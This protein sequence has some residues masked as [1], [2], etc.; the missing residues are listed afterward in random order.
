M[1]RKSLT[2]QRALPIHHSVRPPGWHP[3]DLPS[4][5]GVTTVYV[6]GETTGV[7]WH[8]GDKPVGWAVK[9]PGEPARYLPF[10]HRGGGNHDEATV[11]RWAECELRGKTI[12]NLHTKFDAHMSRKWGVDWVAQGNTLHDIAHAEAL[13]D[14]W[15]RGFSL[16]AIAQRRLGVGKID[17]G[18]KANIAELPAWDVEAYACRDVDLVEQIDL[19]QR[20]LLIEQDLMRVMAL[21]DEVLAVVVEMEH[22]G[23]P[24]DEERLHLW[25][26]QSEQ[27]LEQ[28]LWNVARLAGFQVT[29]SKNADLKR[30]FQ[31]R[32][33]ANPHRTAGGD[34][35]FTAEFMKTI[36]DPAIA[37]AFRAGKLMD[38]RS[39]F[40]E[41]Y[42]KLLHNG[43]LWPSMHQLMTDEGGTVSGR[44]SMARPNLQ[45]VMTPRKQKR[46]YGTFLIPGG[47]EESFVIKQLFREKDGA[48][49]FCADQEQVE[50]RIFA[51]Y[52]EAKAVLDAYA[53]P[54]SFVDFD[55]KPVAV[56][57]RHADMHAIVTLMI[58]LKRELFP[59]DQA[60]NANFARLY[61]SGIPKFAAM[62]GLELDDAEEV[63][64]IYDSQFPEAK[65]LLKKAMGV[66]NERGYVKTT[67]GR[68]CRFPFKDGTFGPAS[69]KQLRSQRERQR[70]HKALNAVIQGSA[71]D[72]NKRCLVETHKERRRLGMT[73]RLTV[74]DELN[75]RLEDAAMAHAA[76][77]VLNQQYVP[78]K[79]PI[80]WSGATG[81][82]WADAK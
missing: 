33:I 27:A 75:S 43:F 78:L 31:S 67:L 76:L 79:V 7:D 35:S 55:G 58:R 1:A 74:H 50:F 72:L 12:T 2:G 57:G 16:E 24:I 18:N 59:R 36:D 20:P 53:A 41:P 61:G 70:P 4:L 29:P 32:G 39:K 81:A 71:A 25:L 62:C 64:G 47:T 65:R 52:S 63:L 3:A 26:K 19:L 21:E 22:N 37:M 11:R 13:L 8:K 40:L 51:H 9:R 56:T 34:W 23:C 73:M 54:E 14:D 42:A 49:W 45:Q 77:D 82:T 30:L 69:S 38:L 6:D 68:R 5:D 10:G 80:L 44:F 48:P 15:T 46:D 17:I 60:K 66:A 28:M